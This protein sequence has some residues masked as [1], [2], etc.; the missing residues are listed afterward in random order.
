MGEPRDVDVVSLSWNRHH[1]IVVMVNTEL[2]L[3]MRLVQVK[4]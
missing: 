1:G 2:F 4:M 3:G